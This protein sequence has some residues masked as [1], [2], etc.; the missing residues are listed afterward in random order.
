[1]SEAAW[2]AGQWYNKSKESTF[3]LWIFCAFFGTNQ[4]IKFSRIGIKQKSYVKVWKFGLTSCI[5]KIHRYLLI[6]WIKCIYCTFLLV[7]GPAYTYPQKHPSFV[8]VKCVF[9]LARQRYLRSLITSNTAT[10][11]IQSMYDVDFQH[12]VYPPNKRKFSQTSNLR[13]NMLHTF[14]IFWILW[15]LSWSLKDKTT[16]WENAMPILWHWYHGRGCFRWRTCVSAREK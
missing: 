1:M 9:R 8:K 3:L 15:S 7:F 13:F 11:T 2:L 6:L 14:L 5:P 12:G 16:T 4:D 10:N